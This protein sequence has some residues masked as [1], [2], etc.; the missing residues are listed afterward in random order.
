MVEEFLYLGSDHCTIRT[1]MQ[2]LELG[3]D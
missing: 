3:L 2:V 1:E